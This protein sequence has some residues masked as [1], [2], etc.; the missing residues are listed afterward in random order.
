MYKIGNYDTDYLTTAFAN[1][2]YCDV[3]NLDAARL[4]AE[5]DIVAERRENSVHIGADKKYIFEF[6]I[7]PNTGFLA[8]E[9]L[10]LKDA[11]LKLCFDRSDVKQVLMCQDADWTQLVADG[12]AGQ[13]V[14]KD[15]YAVVD[16]VSSPNL[17][18]YFDAINYSPIRYE[19]EDCEVFVKS[20]PQGETDIRF[21]NLRGGN[22]PT[23]MFIGF[24]ETAGLN[25][26]NAKSSTRF[27]PHNINYVNISLN[28][29]SVNGYPISIDHNSA[30]QPLQ[31]FINCTNRSCDIATGK[32]FTP[33]EFK[34]NWVWSHCFEAEDGATG[35]LGV[36][37]RLSQAFNES[38]SMVAWIISPAA[39]AIDKFNQ[40]EKVT[41]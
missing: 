33:T 7:T 19:Y 26:S 20:I 4:F 23:H 30:V 39:I 25:G 8:N 36:N 32:M 28:G 27:S 11:E 35:W 17:R 29:N 37:C 15:C 16:Y 40:L 9:D 31:K 2:G 5:T 12:K 34:F 38:M 10:L 1:E 6:C 24:I 14:I 18:T 13:L 3:Y 21:D 41:M 22:I